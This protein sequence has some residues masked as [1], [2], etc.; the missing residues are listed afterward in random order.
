MILE[1]PALDRLCRDFGRSPTLFWRGFDDALRGHRWNDSRKP[2]IGG[3]KQEAQLSLRPFPPSRHD[4]H[5]QIKKFAERSGI[6]FRANHVN[7]QY[8]SILLRCFTA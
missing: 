7:D 6:R 4:H 1:N 3:I 8:S 5:V 2:V